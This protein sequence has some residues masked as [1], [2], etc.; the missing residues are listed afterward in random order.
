MSINDRTWGKEYYSQH[1]HG[2]Y[3]SAI[4]LIP[5]YSR[6]YDVGCGNG[7][8]MDFL[9][10]KHQCWTKGCDIEDG[11]L[12]RCKEKGLDVEKLDIERDVPNEKYDIIT[13][14]AVLEHLQEPIRILNRMWGSSKYIVVGVPNF[15]FLKYRIRH[16]FG[17]TLTSW[18][19]DD[20]FRSWRGITRG[21]GT[22]P[23]PHLRFFTK[24]SL[25]RLLWQT[26]YE[27]VEWCYYNDMWGAFR[28]NFPILASM[29]TVKARPL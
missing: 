1:W 28:H 19:P 2:Y 5:H 20:E 14:M 15:S 18:N 11:C 27:P 6:V 22:Q 29:I 13:M 3:A 8:L 7:G 25:E 4:P 26:H 10:N 21:E 17:E 24:H 23:Y 16:F 9:Q 12:E